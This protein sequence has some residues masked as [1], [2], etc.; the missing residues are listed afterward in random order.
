MTTAT[1]LTVAQLRQAN[2]DFLNSLSAGQV[3]AMGSQL[4]VPIWRAGKISA[5][6]TALM[7]LPGLTAKRKQA[8][9]TRQSYN[10]NTA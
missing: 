10:P 2:R 7:K 1:K 5:V 3:R 6:K 4:G 8:L 9:Q